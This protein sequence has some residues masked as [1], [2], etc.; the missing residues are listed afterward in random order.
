MKMNIEAAVHIYLNL[1]SS[2][3]TSISIPSSQSMLGHFVR[4]LAL[5]TQPKSFRWF[6][7]SEPSLEAME[8]FLLS[9]QLSVSEVVSDEIVRVP[10]KNGISIGSCISF[11][12]GAKGVVLHFDKTMATVGL[13]SGN[14]SGCRRYMPAQ[15]ATDSPYSLRIP[16]VPFNTKEPISNRGSQP[17]SLGVRIIDLLL[18]QYIKQGMTIGI[19]GLD[20]VPVITASK[21]TRV[22]KFPSRPFSSG[23]DLYLDLFA[24]AQEC[25]NPQFLSTILVADFRGFEDACKSIEY[26]SGHLLP[27]SPQSLVASVLQLS[28]GSLSVI[29]AFSNRSDFQ[30]EAEQSVDIGIELCGGSVTNLIP[31]LSRFNLKKNPTSVEDELVGKIVQGYRSKQSVAQKEAMKMFVDYWEKEDIE[32]FETMMRVLPKLA[33]L[34][35]RQGVKYCLIRSLCVLTFNKT[36]KLNSAAVAVF[37]QQLA[38]MIELEESELVETLEEE[39]RMG[40]RVSKELNDAVDAVLYQNRYKFEIT[41]PLV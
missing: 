1:F 22:V 29:A 12:N 2:Y 41:N 9:S 26:Q 25:M 5:Q 23:I 30:N 40:S 38:T 10:S 4:R 31:L 24:V 11:S 19:Y 20:P 16:S 28:H 15:L 17:L 27:I 37:P 13:V 36:S 3:C 7:S 18:R 39:L 14:H 21:T 34:D 32:S 35:I 33:E 8:S 6:S